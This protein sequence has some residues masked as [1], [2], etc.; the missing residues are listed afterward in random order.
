MTEN[1]GFGVA[2]TVEY[3]NYLETAHDGRYAVCESAVDH[4]RPDFDK[5]LEKINANPPQG[6]PEKWFAKVK[7]AA[8]T[9]AQGMALEAET[10]ARNNHPWENRTGDAERGLTGYTVI[11]GVRKPI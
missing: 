11:D 10:W 8:I 9:T 7:A 6:D 4:Y 5:F 2:Q 1:A 3:G